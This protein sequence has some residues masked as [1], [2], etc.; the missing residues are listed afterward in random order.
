MQ[1]WLNFVDLEILGEKCRKI[2]I[3]L[4]MSYRRFVANKL[5]FDINN[6]SGCQVLTLKVHI[7]WGQKIVNCDNQKFFL[8]LIRMQE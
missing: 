4:M 3:Y 5:K 8:L 1:N 6:T 7:V 2:P